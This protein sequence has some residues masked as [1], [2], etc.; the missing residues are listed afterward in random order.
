MSILSTSPTAARHFDMNIAAALGDINAAVIVQQLDYW[1]RKEGVGVTIEGVKYVYNTFVEWVNSQFK[2]LS[3]WQFRKAMNLL[4]SLDI[5]K[6]VRYRSRE[7]NQTNYYTLDRDRLNDYLN[8]QNGQTARSTFRGSLGT[9]RHQIAESIEMV[10]MCNS[11][12][13]DERYQTLEL[14]SSEVSLYESKI[15][16]KDET[17]KQKSDLINQNSLFAAASPKMALEE[18]ENQSNRKHHSER[19]TAS[20]SQI[21]QESTQNKSNLNEEKRIARVDAARMRRSSSSTTGTRMRPLVNKDWSELIPLLD[22]VGVRINRTIKDLLKLYPAEKVEGAIALVRA[23]KREQ[24]IPN[25]SGYFVS[26]LKGDWGN[27]SLVSEK[28]S[29]GEVDEGAIFR[30]WY[31]LA[32]ELGYCSGQEIKEGE[33]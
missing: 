30:H 15:T 22:S 5:V 23:R 13:Q 2:W 28:S 14:R 11:S 29:D 31:D 24:H 7:W 4:R 12:S 19:L 33:Q 9:T 27:K 6:V 20:T 17:T 8:N 21:K 18:E 25:P 16:T 26:A 3:V 32:K 1:M 10:E